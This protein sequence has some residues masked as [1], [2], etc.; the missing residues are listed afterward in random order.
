ME[1]NQIQQYAGGRAVDADRTTDA[2]RA[3][4]EALRARAADSEEAAAAR[5]HAGL[6]RVDVAV[7]HAAVDHLHLG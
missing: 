1:L 7:A 5:R 6:A 3:R 2:L 4:Y